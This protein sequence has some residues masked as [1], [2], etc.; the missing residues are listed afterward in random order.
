MIKGFGWA[1]NP[2]LNRIH[3]LDSSVP[4][5]IMNGSN[6][7]MDKTVGKRLREIRQHSYVRLE[8]IEDAGHHVHADNPESFNEIV[9]DACNLTESNKISDFI[10][11]KKDDLQES[12]EEEIVT[13]TQIVTS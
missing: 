13:Q 12:E 3:K 6:T 2:M 4:I 11:P 8:I 10:V 7:W 9:V 5:T 1:K